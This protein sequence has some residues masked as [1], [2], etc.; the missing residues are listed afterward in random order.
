VPTAMAQAE[1]GEVEAKSVRGLRAKAL[2]HVPGR[3]Y[4]VIV[5]GRPAE[6][7]LPTASRQSRRMRASVAYTGM[8]RGT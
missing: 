4:E 3:D 2:S 7:P 1:H 5:R 6:G 8:R